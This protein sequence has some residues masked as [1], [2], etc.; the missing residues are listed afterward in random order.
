MKVIK[1]DGLEKSNELY[2]ALNKLPAPIS[3]F[4][5]NTDQKHWYKHF[6]KEL[7][8]TNQLAKVDL[9]HL[10]KLAVAV[11]I[12]TQAVAAMNE[13]GYNGGIIQTF[14]TG[15]A[16]ISPH[17]TAQEKA[18][19]QIDDVSKHFGFSFRD[20]FKLEKPNQDDPA[21]TSLFDKF[22]SRKTN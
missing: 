3:R 6:G 1:G 15:A 7:L 17:I 18:I 5:L 4:N 22:N 14:T 13:K 2:Q 9:I 19:K 16:Q 20:R 11:D 8:S 12:Y 21:Q 10:H